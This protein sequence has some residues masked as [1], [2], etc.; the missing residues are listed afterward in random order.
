MYLT[1]VRA[2]LKDMVNWE[3]LSLISVAWLAIAFATV[4]SLRGETG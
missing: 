2:A 4:H 1:A 3:S